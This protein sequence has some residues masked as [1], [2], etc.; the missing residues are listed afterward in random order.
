MLLGWTAA[1]LS[2]SPVGPCVPLRGRVVLGLMSPPT[3]TGPQPAGSLLSLVGAVRA[4]CPVGLL[5]KSHVR[6]M[7]DRMRDRW[8]VDARPVAHE[9]DPWGVVPRPGLG[10]VLGMFGYGYTPAIQSD[11][12][13]GWGSPAMWRGEGMRMR[14]QTH[15]NRKPG[16][17]HRRSMLPLGGG[18]VVRL[19]EVLEITGLSR[20]TIWR[21][22]RDGSFPSP[23][24]LGGEHARAVGWW[25]QDIYDWI[26]SLSPAA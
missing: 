19:P 12:R 26:D 11:W 23:F 24:R 1:V 8:E 21:R 9:R 5:A 18:R 15:N 13:A 17:S 3:T 20:T 14:T 6:G 10:V 22:E 25:E 4:F 16:V 7:R 2:P